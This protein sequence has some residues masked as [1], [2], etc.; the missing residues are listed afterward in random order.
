MRLAETCKKYVFECM[1]SLFT[2]ITYKQTFRLPPWSDFSDYRRCCLLGYSPHFAPIKLNLQLSH[3][4]HF[5]F[6]TFL[7]ASRDYLLAI[8]GVPW[9]VDVTTPIS[10]SAATC[11]SSLCLFPLHKGTKHCLRVH[12]NPV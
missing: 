11:C 4:A 3:C 7:L 5:F 8:F 6:N 12:P 1:K 2:K 9:L 10:A